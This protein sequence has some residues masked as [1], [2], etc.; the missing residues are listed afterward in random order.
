M[1]KTV[2]EQINELFALET[3]A[4]GRIVRKNKFFF[5]LLRDKEFRSQMRQCMISI[6]GNPYRVARYDLGGCL[7]WAEDYCNK[8]NGLN[9]FITFLV[10]NYCVA[11]NKFSANRE[12]LN[13][14]Y[15]EHNNFTFFFGA[16]FSSEYGPST[17]GG[18]YI[19]Y[20]KRKDGA[21]KRMREKASVLYKNFLESNFLARIENKDEIIHIP[22]V[23]KNRV[24]EC[25][26]IAWTAYADGGEFTLHIDKNF[27]AIYSSDECD[28]NFHSCMTDMGFETFYEAIPEANAC[29]ITN[30]DGLIVARAILWNDVDGGNGNRYRLLDRLYSTDQNERLQTILLNK[31]LAEQKCDLYKPVGCACSDATDILTAD[32][33]CFDG[34]LRIWYDLEPMEYVPYLDT[35]KYYSENGNFATND[36]Y[37]EYDYNLTGTGGENPSQNYCNY[38]DEHFSGRSIHSDYHDSDFEDYDDRITYSDYEYDVL[39]KDDDDVCY[40]EALDD[41]LLKDHAVQTEDSG[42]WFPRNEA[43]DYGLICV[44]DGVYCDDHYFEYPENVGT[45][46]EENYEIEDYKELVAKTIIFEDEMDDEFSIK[47]DELYFHYGSEA[48]SHFY[49]INTQ[50]WAYIKDIDKE[51]WDRYVKCAMVLGFYLP[52]D[53]IEDYNKRNNIDTNEQNSKDNE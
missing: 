31:V 8:P 47:E 49:I 32:G 15:F 4:D 36:E 40:S 11:E 16:P 42:N 53:I 12:R 14:Q 43:C 28:G 25:F 23:V 1:E 50:H 48:Y 6:G 41:Y 10:Y 52:D 24:I 46:D 33:V 3:K 13:T 9:N 20:T 18:K 35:F 26:S 22:D 38:F 39:V 5:E 19:A 34:V 17:A 37:I 29:Y 45:I 7:L 44:E 51:S 2:Y 30:E 27:H 21:K